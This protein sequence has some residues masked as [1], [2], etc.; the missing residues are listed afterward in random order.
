MHSLKYV[1]FFSDPLYGPI[2]ITQK[3]KDVIETLNFQ[4]L[5]RIKQ[6]GIA[7]FVFPGANHSRFEHSLG[8]MHITSRILQNLVELDEEETEIILLSALLHDLG[9]GPFSHVFEELFERNEK[10]IPEKKGTKLKDHEDFTRYILEEDT[11]IREALGEYATRIINFMFNAKPVGGV[12]SEIISGDLGSDRIDYLVRD[13]YYAGLGHRP[14]VETLISHLKLQTI[15]PKEPRI[16]LHINGYKSAELLITTRYYHYSIIAHNPKVRAVAVTFLNLMDNFLKKKDDAARFMLEAF[17]EHDDSVILSNLYKFGGNLLHSFKKGKNVIPLYI[18]EIG[19]I[20]SGLT[21]YCLYRYFFDRKGLQQFLGMATTKLEKET[22][23]KK[24]IVDMQIAKHNTPDVILQLN[25]YDTKERWI[26][27]F[28]ADNSRICRLIPAEQLL[29]S[30][31]CVF[32]K[33]TNLKQNETKELAKKISE[34][35]E[36]LLSHKFLVPL[37]VSSIKN[38]GLHFIDK[39]YAILNALRQFYQE[40]PWKTNLQEKYKTEVFRGT[41]RLYDIIYLCFKK[42]GIT[43]LPFNNFYKE[44]TESFRYS[45]QIFSVL[46]ILG[47]LEILG[48]KYVPVP[49]AGNKPYHKVYLIEPREKI[50]SEKVYSPITSFNNLKDKFIKIIRGLEWDE[51]F[52]DF[53]TNKCNK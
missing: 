39:F 51:Y 19:N 42:V 17:T 40:K 25:G 35:R 45:N 48:L 41:S 29:G 49:G 53:F 8:T 44:E 31:I 14:D 33:Q 24:L 18:K 21:A 15:N 1:D 52:A 32:S 47:N 43:D 46:N 23:E 50:I 10:Y 36:L 28:L 3:E 27:P 38:N 9:H 5:K 22:G 12:P 20:R 13:T 34:N 37:T 6:L 16:A 7:N 11:D 26:S 30:L 4:R 2:H